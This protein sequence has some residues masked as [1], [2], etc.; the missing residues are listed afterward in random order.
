MGVSYLAVAPQ[1]PLARRAAAASPELDAFI[2]ELT[3]TAVA[4]AD[5]ATM[6]K[7]GVDT[8]LRATHPLTGDDVPI[9]VANFVLMSYGSGAVMSVPGHDQRD[10][11]FASKYGLPIVQVVASQS[12]DFVDLSESAYAEKGPLMNSGTFDGLDFEDGFNA[13]VEALHDKGLGE[14]T[15]NFRL[16]DWGVSRQRYWGA[17]IPVVNCAAC[18]PVPVSD[19]QLPVIL[20]TEVAFDGVASPIK[21]MTDFTQ[22]DCPNCG[23]PAERE[24][25]TFDTFMESSWYY[26]RYT[27]SA[28]TT[29][30]LGKEANYWLEVDQYVGG[31]EHAILHLLYARF[32]HKLMRDEGLINSSEPFKRLLTQGMVLKDGA[33]MSKSKGNTVDPQ[34]LIDRFGADTVRLFSMFAAPPEQSLEWSDAGV[35]GSHRFLKRLWRLVQDRQKHAASIDVR[36]VDLNKAQKDLRRKTHE[37]IAK[38]SDDF[39]RRQTFNTA[40]AAVM[41]LC[42][43]IS[44]HDGDAP[45]DAAVVDEALTAAVLLLA[46][47]VPHISE[48]LYVELTGSSSLDASWPVL[49]ESAL[50]RDEIEV[51]VQVNGKVR[52]KLS[53]AAQADKDS[54]ERAAMEH[55]NVKRFVEGLTVRKVIV[56]PGKLVNVVAN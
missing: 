20:P 30:M 12:G 8:G 16:R 35:E 18:G 39:G 46:P 5:L 27:S 3:Q 51:V 32:F 26:A 9:W 44:R 36:E 34:A 38:V 31:I 2:Q 4:E 25:D 53:V 47:I 17:P 45:E 29:A 48:A 14:K 56:V 23:R 10:W 54:I 43:E 6:E 42:N 55:E 40:V 33:K 15:V 11:E 24:T 50:K 19:E 28:D 52:A 37:T 7:R 41:E 1:H 13:I 49:D 22:T 21:S